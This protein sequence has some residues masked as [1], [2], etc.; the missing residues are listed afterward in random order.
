M[1]HGLDLLHASCAQAACCLAAAAASQVTELP[2][3]SPHPLTAHTPGFGCWCDAAAGNRI[4]LLWKCERVPSW[5]VQRCPQHMLEP[6]TAG[7]GHSTHRVTRAV[8][9]SF[10]GC[11]DTHHSSMPRQE[12][13]MIGGL[14]TAHELARLWQG[15][16]GH[17]SS[18]TTK[19]TFLT[20]LASSQS[21][22]QRETV[23]Q[24]RMRCFW[25]CC[26]TS[27]KQRV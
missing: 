6:S 12:E 2:A 22:G 25:G 4:L 21:W 19:R 7:R 24:A 3:P 27:L 10:L 11:S 14:L 1:V 13:S 5:I 23:A 8:P 26:T 16:E 9:P 18:S 15:T 17:S 20:G